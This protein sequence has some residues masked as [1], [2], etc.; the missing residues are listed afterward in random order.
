MTIDSADHPRV[1]FESTVTAVGA[2]VADFVDA[3]LLVLFGTQ[4]P[5]ELHDICVLHERTGT[6]LDPA[7]RAGDV[8]EIAGR[9]IEILAVGDAVEANFIELGHASIKAD[10]RAEAAL[11]GDICVPVGP[12]PV[13]APGQ[14]I[15]I[16]AP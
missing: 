13:P 12:L 16:I 1:R 4:A 6:F 14:V 5:P 2:Q 15:R 3:G 11:P 8:I 10:G 9:A 7:P